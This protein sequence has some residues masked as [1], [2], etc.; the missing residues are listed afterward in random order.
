MTGGPTD[1]KVLYVL[2]RGRGG[3][4]IFANVLG[5][6]EG[7]FSAGEIRSLIDPVLRTGSPCGCGASMESCEVWASVVRALEPDLAAAVGWQRAVVRERNLVRL[8]RQKRG[9]LDEWPVLE[10]Y[11][12]TLA[13]LYGRLAEATGAGVIVDS[14]KRPSF[15]AVLRLV[16]NIDVFFVHLVRDPRASA[17][18]WKHRRYESALGG[19]VT[20]RNA[21]DSTIRWMVLNVEAEA[22]LRTHGAGKTLRLGYE[23]FVEDPRGAVERVVALL[24]EDGSGTPFVGDRT[25]RLAVN[26]TV[27]GNPSRFATGLIAL[28]DSTGWRNQQSRLDRWT[29]TVVASPLLRAY[30]Y[31][32]RLGARP[33]D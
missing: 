21:F 3:S 27:A 24:G 8:L 19:E 6:L 22:L 13:H 20:R 2:G 33:D 16:P 11:V 7:F 12:Q 23:G 17:Y 29:A 31:K 15:G 30:G 26:H 1:A 32:M 9:E 25:V 10:H 4:T 18:S 14:S 5:A 28:E